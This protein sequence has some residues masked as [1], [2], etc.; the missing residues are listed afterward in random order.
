MNIQARYRKGSFVTVLAVKK[1][2]REKWD[3]G[4]REGGREMERWKE[5]R[6]RY[7]AGPG[8]SQVAAYLKGVVPVP[9][10]CSC[11]RSASVGGWRCS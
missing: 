8:K 6:S 9:V 1:V 7:E 5:N 3:G 2:L 4:G 10:V 11:C